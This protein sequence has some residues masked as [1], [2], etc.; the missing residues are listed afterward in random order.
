MRFRNV[1]MFGAAVLAGLIAGSLMGPAPVNAVARELIELQRDVT[2][3]LQGQKDLSTQITQDHTVM[4]TLVEQSGDNVGKLS[5][6]MSGLQ[7]SVQDVQA[8]GGARL[9][10]MSTQVQGVSDNLE[11][12]KSRMGKLNQQLVDLQNT[13]QS[14]DAKISSGGAP[15]GTVP[16]SGGTTA[17]PTGASTAMPAASAAPSAD[18][19]Y[20][21]GLRD[22]TSGKYDL[23]RSEFQDYLKYYGDTDLA[24]NAQFYLGEI[25]YSQ[26][27]YSNAVSEYEKVLTT[28]PKSFKLAPARLKKGM[29]LIELGQ[30]PSGIRELREVVKRYPGTEEERRARSKLK[31][32]GAAVTAG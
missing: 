14:L 26:K 7:K 19:L 25:A 4:R 30:K 18:T 27:Q 32:L 11:E 29:A 3:L 15:A 23:A 10:T 17:T 13:V 9:D 20:S 22:I 31:E 21:N 8:N 12:I 24:S 6:T 1:A 2:S 16:A 5:A 28:Y